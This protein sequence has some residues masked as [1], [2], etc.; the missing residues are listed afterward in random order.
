MSREP[1]PVLVNPRAGRGGEAPIRRIEQAL[2]EAGAVAAVEPVEAHLLEAE[3]RRLAGEGIPAVGVAG[4][5]GTL[6]TAASVLAGTRTAL[7]PIPTGTLNHFARRV[8]IESV[9]QGAAAIAS[10][11]RLDLPVGIVDDRAF[12]NT[13]TFGLYADVVRRR[14]RL[15]RWLGKWPAAV[16]GFAGRI[17]GFRQMDLVL[18][19]D[20]QRLRRRTPLLWV[21]MGWGSF[22]LVH[23]AQ[24]RR[25]SPDLEI[26]VLRPR[27]RIGSLALMARLSVA[28][29]SRVWPVDDPAL[30]FLHARW[31]LIHADHR[32]GVTLDGEIDRLSTPVFIGIQ[33]EALSVIGPA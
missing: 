18:E 32:I 4:G 31:A 13:A 1:V 29:R 12:L 17:A 8:G 3:L 28:I 21:G 24:E 27:G 20:G 25:A 5:D 19:V 33:D 22:P 9:E 6:V 14:E 16:V 26:V 30:E 7:V 23:E 2:A 10:G 15:R 11:R